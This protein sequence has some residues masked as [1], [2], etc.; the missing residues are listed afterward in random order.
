MK[1]SINHLDGTLKKVLIDTTIDV[2]DLVYA[3]MDE[4]GSSIAHFMSLVDQGPDR[5]GI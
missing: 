4:I 1:P 5:E 2:Y 3:L